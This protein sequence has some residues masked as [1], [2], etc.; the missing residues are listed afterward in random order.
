M[1]RTLIP[2]SIRAQVKR[3]SVIVE[4]MVAVT[5]GD[6][7]VLLKLVDILMMPILKRGKEE[8]IKTVFLPAPERR[9]EQVLQHLKYD[10]ITI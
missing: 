7:I 2:K 4:H 8:V 10:Y 1:K 3:G 9:G 6:A 5:I